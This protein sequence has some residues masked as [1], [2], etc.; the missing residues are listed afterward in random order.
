MEDQL[1]SDEDL[2]RREVLDVPAHP[3]ETLDVRENL[4]F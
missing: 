4:L 2:K 3:R 1:I